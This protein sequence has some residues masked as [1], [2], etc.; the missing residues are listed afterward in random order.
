[1]SEAEVRQRYGELAETYTRTFG[2][3]ATVDPQDLAFLKAN[4]GACEG[5]VLD[6][7]CGPGHLTAYLAGLGLD[8]RGLDLVPEFIDTATSRWPSIE[9]SV[10]SLRTL[11]VPDRSLGGILAWY[12]LIHCEPTELTDILKELRRAMAPGATLV[13][14][15]FD[16][17][18][19]E[20][21]AHKVTTAYRCPIDEMSR[22]L[23]IAGFTETDRLQRP[24][25][26]DIR[27]HA[28]M[29]ARVPSSE[30]ITLR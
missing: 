25:T 11:E 4:L 26:T 1:M 5:P 9:F 20:A 30:N 8:A 21:F 18:A 2:D 23:A 16:G 29:A 17:D 13:V 7:G 10:G 28:V 12:S 27:P 14:G 22:L 19:V 24:G 6:V 3:V 15:F